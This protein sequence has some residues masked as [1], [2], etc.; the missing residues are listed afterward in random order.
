MTIHMSTNIHYAA[1]MAPRVVIAGENPETVWL[2][3]G[4]TTTNVTV[5]FPS[6][7]RV[8]DWADEVRMAAEKLVEQET[9]R[10]MDSLDSQV[11]VDA[12]VGA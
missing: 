10:L 2:E 5:F 9:K 7:D 12:E 6:L 1:E 11:A 8:L 3:V 4:N